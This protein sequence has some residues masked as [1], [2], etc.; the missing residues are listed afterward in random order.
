[1]DEPFVM[2]LA[3]APTTSH[4]KRSAVIDFE[5]HGQSWPD[6]GVNVQVMQPGQPNCRYHSEPVQEDFLVL[7]GE[8]IAIVDGEERPLRQWD[9]LHCPA[10]V[11]HV[12]I[13]AGDGPC[14]VLMIGSR[15]KDEAHYPVNDVAAKYGASVAEA[16]DE[17][18]EAYADWRREP[19]TAT[20]NPWPLAG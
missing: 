18:A 5:A 4:P 6:T 10:G 12:F 15:H 20:A 19:W 16:T 1:M 9:F 14:A 11:E 13:G 7:H 8:C 17:P 2:N 3:D